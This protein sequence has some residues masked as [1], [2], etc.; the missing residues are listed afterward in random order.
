MGPQLKLP[1]KVLN[2]SDL[3]HCYVT[4][5]FG[6]LLPFDI[7]EHT[8]FNLLPSD[9]EVSTDFLFINKIYT[10]FYSFDF[11]VYKHG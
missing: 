7:S 5:I 10:A 1:F 2:G 6:K 3:C 11:F 9:E 4:H 8:N